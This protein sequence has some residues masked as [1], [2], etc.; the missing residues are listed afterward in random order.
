[1][2]EVSEEKDCTLVKLFAL[3]VD[4]LYS[5]NGYQ[6]SASSGRPV[7]ELTSTLNVSLNR[8]LPESA[9]MSIFECTVWVS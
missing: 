7:N 6:L 8:M 2:W 3:L 1:M 4:F 5:A 9:M